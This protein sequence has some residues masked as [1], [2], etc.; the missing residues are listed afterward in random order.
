MYHKHF[1]F[2][3][4]AVTEDPK[5]NIGIIEGFASTFN[6]VD[7]DGDIMLPGAFASSIADL[8]AKNQVL[9]MLA[10]HRSNEQIGAY[11][12]ADIS[13]NAI[14]LV[15]KGQ[16]DLNVQKAAEFFSLAK[17]GFLTS[18]SIGFNIQIENIQFNE[19]GTRTFKEV[20][21]LEI[22]LVAIPANPSALI[23]DVKN[24][25]DKAKDDESNSITLQKLDELLLS[26]QLDKLIA[27]GQTNVS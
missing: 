23:T 25:K 8:R 4:K 20:E 9:P 6:N 2:E 15:V 22:S 3:L 19:D 7:R 12:A 5:K 10:G 11:D 14:G 26:A 27:E 21:L 13:E 1:N 16:L 18:F 24:T 17:N